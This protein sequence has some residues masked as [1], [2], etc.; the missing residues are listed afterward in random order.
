MNLDQIANIAHQVKTRAEAETLKA[1]CLAKGNTE[2]AHVVN[3]I[4]LNRFPTIAKATGGAT[5][6]VASVNGRKEYFD[7][8]K[9]AY[10]WLINQFI[11]ITPD[12]LD[13]Y[14]DFQSKIKSRAKGRRFARSPRDLFP[15]GS[16]RASM[17]SHYA[18]LVGGWFADVN[19][20]HKDKF[21]T[22]I[23]VAYKCDLEYKKDWDFQPT[24]STKQLQEHQEAVIQGQ[25]MLAELMAL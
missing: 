15:P 8:G 10:L 7:S 6:T 11:A 1:N 13:L 5:P 23:K 21:A 25:R 14:L 17:E 16:N 20:D 12:A 9:E 22:L 24:G 3:E 2:A 19:L 18:S 4:L